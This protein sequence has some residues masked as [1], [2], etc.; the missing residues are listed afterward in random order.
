M[1]PMGHPRF[2]AL[3]PYSNAQ[4]MER[5][6]PLIAAIASPLRFSLLSPAAIGSRI[7]RGPPVRK[8]GRSRVQC[9]AP[10]PLAIDYRQCRRW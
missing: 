2:C 9:C 1:L 7:D 6:F 5:G 10:E 8:I 4:S 3:A